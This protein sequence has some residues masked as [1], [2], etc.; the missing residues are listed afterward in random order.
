MKSGSVELLADS[1]N[2]LQ[3]SKRFNDY[4]ALLKD[5]MD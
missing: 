3:K 5:I 1:L 2:R 4:Q